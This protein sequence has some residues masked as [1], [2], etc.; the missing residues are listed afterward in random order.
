M[1]DE[2][3]W[4]TF[5]EPCKG[6]RIRDALAALGSG[7]GIDEERRGADQALVH[8]GGALERQQLIHEGVIQTTAQLRQGFGHDKVLLRTIE[9]HC[10]EAT[11]LHDC[12]VGAQPLTDGFVRSAHCVFE[13]CQGQPDACRERVAPIGAHFRF[14]LNG[15]LFMPP[16]AGHSTVRSVG[17]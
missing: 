9:G 16:L 6:G 7:K 5:F 1:Q 12:H 10:V 3:S 17:L 2:T 4:R 8:R 11:R 13:Q 15:I 14:F